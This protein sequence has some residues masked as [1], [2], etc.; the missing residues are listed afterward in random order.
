M[1]I[2]LR[3]GTRYPSDPA[4]TRILSPQIARAI[5]RN[6]IARKRKK[7]LK[8]RIYLIVSLLKVDVKTMIITVRLKRIESANQ[9]RGDSFIAYLPSSTISMNHLPA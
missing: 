8:L 4:S 7:I 5:R 1:L 3:K 9:P 6:T 2:Q